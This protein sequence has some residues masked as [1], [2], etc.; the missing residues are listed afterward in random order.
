MSASQHTQTPNNAEWQSEREHF[1][2]LV[3]AQHDLLTAQG[4]PDQTMQ[5]VIDRA[6]ALTDADGVVVLTNSS[7]TLYYSYVNGIF[8]SQLYQSVSASEGLTGECCANKALIYLPDASQDARV[9]QQWRAGLDIRALAMAPLYSGGDLLG[10]IMIGSLQVDA[11]SEDNLRTMEIVSG[12]ACAVANK[13]A[14]EEARQSLLT[15]RTAALEE[16][17]ESE[18]LFRSAIGAMQEGLVVHDA[19]GQLQMNNQRAGEILD[20]GDE[21]LF[22]HTGSNRKCRTL[23]EDGAEFDEPEYPA[24]MAL[25]T[26]KAQHNIVMGV[27]FGDG[28]VIWLMVGAAPLLMPGMDQPY[29]VVTTFSDITAQKQHERQLKAHVGQIED[30][31]VVLGYQ[32]SELEHANQQLEM[33]ATT[34]GLTGLKNHRTFQDRL[35]EEVMR[36]QRHLTPLSMVLLD[37]DQFKQFNDNFGHPAGDEVLRQVARVLSECVREHDLVARYGGEE[38][39][40]VLP[41]TDGPGAAAI[42]ERCRMSIES[43]EW[44]HRKVTAS[45]GVASVTATTVGPPDLIVAA[46]TALYD[47]KHN[48]RNRV[49]MA[50]A[51][52]ETT[53]K[54]A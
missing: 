28:S 50:C 33:L 53:L 51:I 30:L 31:N 32:T 41:N 34:D 12:W 49:S 43:A 46:D 42:A 47:A 20:L 44:T 26:G 25:S 3:S 39:V 7:G 21:D 40:L 35:R 2:A 15:A 24:R 38:F 37:V 27:E 14:E 36:S 18:N 23:H 17:R 22:G 45:F 6:S 10:A 16:L 4:D 11:F 13:A 19:Y 48:G 29:A 8:E 1:S 9:D 5:M 54:A 52:G